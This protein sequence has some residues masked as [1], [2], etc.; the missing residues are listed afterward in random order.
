MD[1]QAFQESLQG[2]LESLC[3]LDEDDKAEVEGALGVDVFEVERVTSFSDEGVLTMNAGLVVTL[4]D[5]SRFQ[6]TIVQDHRG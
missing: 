4:S 2:I 1:E 6:L 3:Y 5:G